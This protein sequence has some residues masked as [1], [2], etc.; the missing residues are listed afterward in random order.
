M[1]DAEVEM[2]IALA[3]RRNWDEAAC[4]YLDNCSDKDIGLF[5]NVP[6][7]LV[8]QIRQRTMGPTRSELERTVEQKIRDDLEV[9]ERL[10]DSK[11][12]AG[13]IEE[14]RGHL[15]NMRSNLKTAD[16]ILSEIERCARTCDKSSL[17]SLLGHRLQ[18]FQSCFSNN[19]KSSVVM[20]AI[21]RRQFHAV[22]AAIIH[23]DDYLL[24]VTD[25]DC[26]ITEALNETGLMNRILREVKLE[27]LKAGYKPYFGGSP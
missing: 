3:I 4:D 8:I 7:D 15:R 22:E 20:R 2:A 18:E 10:S 1:I 26:N 6:I 25:S 11:E 13:W 16:E 17:I 19:L 23:V 24:K 5:L 27:H 14:A 9:I 21:Y 12:V